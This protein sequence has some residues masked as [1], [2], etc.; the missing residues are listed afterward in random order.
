MHHRTSCPFSAKVNTF[1]C[2]VCFFCCC[3]QVAAPSHVSRRLPVLQRRRMQ[4]RPECRTCRRRDSAVGD[5]QWLWLGRVGSLISAGLGFTWREFLLGEDERE[6]R[7]CSGFPLNIQAVLK[8]P[9]P[10]TQ[11]FTYMD[12][13]IL[14]LLSAWVLF[15]E[16]LMSALRVFTRRA[17][18]FFSL[19]FS[20]A[21]SVDQELD[22]RRNFSDHKTCQWDHH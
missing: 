2:S 20:F 12:D 6:S 10:P 18:F 14:F 1:F 4:P 7:C 11:T 16:R 19:Y 15:F 3:S 17:T 22:A 13:S 8:E 9:R 5:G 21:G